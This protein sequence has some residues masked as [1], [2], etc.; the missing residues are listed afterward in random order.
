MARVV[1]LR[2]SSDKQQM[3]VSFKYYYWC[4]VL[5]IKCNRLRFFCR[6]NTAKNIQCDKFIRS[7]IICQC[8]HCFHYSSIK[9]NYNDKSIF[10]IKKMLLIKSSDTTNRQPL[11][12]LISTDIS[13]RFCLF[14]TQHKSE[15]GD[16]ESQ[17]GGSENCG[18]ATRSITF[19][20]FDYTFCSKINMSD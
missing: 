15:R 19:T 12:D 16:K 17:Q 5:T 14:C 11:M 1:E 9:C 10:T 8:S 7:F 6:K 13:L 20:T 18:N 4:H 3:V 2:N